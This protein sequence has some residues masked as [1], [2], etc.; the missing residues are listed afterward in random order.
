MPASDDGTRTATEPLAR[1]DDVA[2][3]FGGRAVLHEVSLT[4]EPGAHLEVR[5]VNGS[6]KTTLLR[7]LAGVCRPA[8]GRRR[9]VRSVAFVPAV[10]DPP[11]L[12]VRSWLAAVRRRS[13][14]AHEALEVLGFVGEVDDGCR[15][16]SLGNLRKVLLA[17]AF[18]STSPLVVIDEGR[19][20]LDA[21]GVDG[22]GRLIG[23]AN[24]RGA[25]VVLA[26]QGG[27][28]VPSGA[29]T[30]VVADGHVMRAAPAPSTATVTFAGPDAAVGAL[31]REASRLGFHRVDTERDG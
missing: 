3:R 31:W 4:V 17:D 27:R 6:G 23:D 9:A 12:S 11:P 19:E 5:G 22:L 14:S 21:A 30:I 2:V 26:D 1:L 10:V 25:A 24:A 8:H 13:R 16:L 29:T 15:R 7:V 18:T 28:P 20:G